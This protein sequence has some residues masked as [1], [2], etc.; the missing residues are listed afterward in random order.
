MLKYFFC[1]SIVI[2][3]FMFSLD[4]GTNILISTKAASSFNKAESL[5]AINAIT[6]ILLATSKPIFGKLVKVLGTVISLVI[7]L[8]CLT[9]GY[10]ICS[11]SPS[12]YTLGVGLCIWQVGFS[13]FQIILQILIADSTNLRYRSFFSVLTNS[14][15]FF[16]L[17]YL[18]GKISNHFVNNLSWRSGFYIYA[19]CYIPSILPIIL[20]LHYKQRRTVK[21]PRHKNSSTSLLFKVKPTLSQRII[22]F[23]SEVDLLG[24]YLLF[25]LLIYTF[26]PIILANQIGFISWGS[27]TIPAMLTAGLGMILPAFLYWE[28]Y[29]AVHPVLP[30]RLL[31]NKTIAIVCVINYFDFTSF[32]LAF[33]QLLYFTQVATD[34]TTNHINYYIYTQALCM[35]IFAIS[36]SVVA[37]IYQIRWKFSVTVALFVRLFGIALMLYTSGHRSTSVMVLTQVLQGAGGGIVAVATQVGAQGAVQA[38]DL[39]LA[40][41]AVLLVAEIG[42]VAGSSAASAINV[43]YLPQKIQELF[44]HFSQ[45][46]IQSYV[47]DPSKSRLL[48][49]VGTPARDLMIKAFSNNMKLL[50]IPASLLSLIP[51][52]ASRFLVDFNLDQR[53]N[54]VETPDN[55][56]ANH[57]ATMTQ[58]SRTSRTSI[59][60]ALSELS[61]ES[62][63]VDRQF[64]QALNTYASH[65]NLRTS[66][67]FTGGSSNGIFN[68]YDE[69]DDDDNERSLLSG[70]RN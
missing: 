6:A 28:I 50:I 24:L 12:I 48:G 21:K 34:W 39:A 37:F 46:Q 22:Q 45:E 36:W 63:G 2:S 10:L 27:P 15:W 20:V 19:L 64:N 47:G 69:I 13:G 3:S 58:E 29:C 23:A 1:L 51:I 9:T 41:A 18:N 60:S 17:F 59:D 52:I 40:T 7:C 33:S 65:D 44:P 14:G 55:M 70:N 11:V 67:T 25:N 38:T 32:N 68:E 30:L 42:N 49:A 35:T 54:V 5:N 43:Q 57:G 26:V 56:I 53:K 4:N 66:T 31:K 61:S 16:V 8:V 62:E